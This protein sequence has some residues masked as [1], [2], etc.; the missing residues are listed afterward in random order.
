MNEKDVELQECVELDPDLYTMV[1]RLPMADVFF[2]S[3]IARESQALVEE[4]GF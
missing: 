1:V 3:R 2:R 4:M